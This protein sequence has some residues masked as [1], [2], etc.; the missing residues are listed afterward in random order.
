MIFPVSYSLAGGRGEWALRLVETGVE[1]EARCT[2]VMEITRPDDLED[3]ADLGLTLAEAKLL[4][5]RVQQ[6]I[7]AA[8]ARGLPLP[9]AAELSVL[10]RNVP[11]KGLS[12][13]SD[14]DA[15]WPVT[16]R[17]PRY[18]CAECR[19]GEA[20]GRLAI[21]LPVDAELDQLQAHLLA[22]MS[23]R[24]AA[25]VLEQ[26]FPVDAGKSH[27]TLRTHTLKLGERLQD[28]A[29]L[30]PTTAATAIAIS[31]D[32]TFIRS[33]EDGERPIVLECGNF[34]GIAQ[35]QFPG[36]ADSASLDHAPSP[37]N[38]PIERS[39]IFLIL[40]CH[41]LGRLAKINARPCSQDG[42]EIAYTGS[43]NG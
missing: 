33:C 6:E 38:S 18:R 4:Q 35:H 19:A 39:A 13:P 25:S 1:G 36:S 5:A 9:L 20:R 41:R 37:A 40:Y 11:S 10:P 2:D 29:V 34:P 3:I 17:L 42:L 27:E 21:E 31:V 26:M 12:G 8:Q 24:V 14:R 30:A 7:S 22:L 23:Y 43:T 28:R 16:V 32:S 15:F